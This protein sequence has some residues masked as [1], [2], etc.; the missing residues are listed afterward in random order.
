MTK[1]TREPPVVLSFAEAASYLGVSERTLRR[2]VAEKVVPHAKVGGLIR[3]RRIALEEWLAAAER[4]TMT[5]V[6][7]INQPLAEGPEVITPE[8]PAARVDA[9]A[10]KYA[11]VPTSVDG[12]IRRKQEEIELEDR[13][14]QAKGQ[15][16]D[17]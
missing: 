3:F 8:E 5:Q 6:P 13:G 14:W 9:I 17:A 1:E 10:G 2:W 7:P 16:R 4:Q 11:W 12:F 15:S